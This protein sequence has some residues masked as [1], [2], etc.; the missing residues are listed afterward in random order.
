MMGKDKDNR[1]SSSSLE[2]SSLSS[3][4]FILSMPFQDA[5][6]TLSWGRNMLC[7]LLGETSSN[8]DLFPECYNTHLPGRICLWMQP[9][10]DGYG[11]N[12]LFS[13]WILRPFQRREFVLDT[14]NLVWPKAHV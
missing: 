3:G 2:L 6:R 9:W 12:Q 5:P 10:Q 14:R 8:I 11:G 1:F 13:D 7:R 4:S